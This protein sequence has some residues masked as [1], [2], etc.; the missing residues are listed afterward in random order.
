[1]GDDLIKGR[2][3]AKNKTTKRKSVELGPWVEVFAWSL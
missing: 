2:T 3:A 1:M